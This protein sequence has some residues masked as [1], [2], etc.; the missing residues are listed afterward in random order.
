M[1]CELWSHNECAGYGKE[2]YVIPVAREDWKLQTV[3][4][5]N[6]VILNLD[7][8]SYNELV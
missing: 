3:V 7:L 6:D 8:Y 2:E 4:G 5:S 1:N